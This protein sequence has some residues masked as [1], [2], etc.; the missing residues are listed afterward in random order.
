MGLVG[1]IG[2][3][4]VVVGAGI[5]GLTTAGILAGR[6][7]RVVLLDRDRLPDE[8]VPR[9][10]VPQGEQPHVL[11][12]AGRHALGRLFPD[13]VDELVAAG[14]ADFDPGM[15]LSFHRWGATW[16]RVPT[17]Q[18]LVVCSRPLLEHTIRRRVAGLPGV[19]FLDGTAVAALVGG[20]GRVTG[21]R[22][23]DGET[24][25][26][27]L[28]VDCT[29]K[30]SPSNRW[31]AALG[32]PVPRVSEVAIGLGYA[33]RLYRRSPGD[34]ADA[35]AVLVLPSPP[36]EV[37]AGVAL[38]IEGDRW[39]I[40]L[41]GWHDGFPRD[42]EA[43]DRYARELPHPGIAGLLERCEPLTGLAVYQFPASR[44]RHFEKLREHPVGYLALGDAVCSFNPIYGQGMTCAALEAVELGALL[45]RYGAVTPALSAD[46]YR[47]VAT[48]IATP[49]QFAA[50]ARCSPGYNT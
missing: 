48:V 46:W 10:G 42:Q 21:V 33:T 41:A 26:T 47:R 1:R 5:A 35:R 45:D 2:K 49:W 32:F 37:R 12:T 43:F 15:D 22:R 29:G 9:R 27:D 6:F 31:L 25:D 30:A 19:E 3:T 24:M 11:L 20:D 8:P 7:D 44:R 39:I 23:D 50:G 16:S 28:V 14:A 36:D 4:A 18:R 38:Q 34:L 40:S 17:K 13:L